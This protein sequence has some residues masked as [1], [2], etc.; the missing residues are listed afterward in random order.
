MILHSIKLGNFRNYENIE[1]SLSNGINIIYGDNAQ[2]KTN[3]L[4]SI[5]VLALTKSH[6]SFIDHNLIKDEKQIS[7]VSG[8]VEKNGISTNYEVVIEQKKKKCFIDGNEIKKL[9]DYISNLNIV[10]FYPEDLEI[11]KG[12]PDL[13]RRYINME[14]SQLDRNYFTILND[15]NRLLKMRNDSL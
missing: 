8:R 4:E 7:K 10:I 5:Y 12:A 13:R 15:Y 2:G 14:I 11:I 9:S 1:V 6:R 3:L